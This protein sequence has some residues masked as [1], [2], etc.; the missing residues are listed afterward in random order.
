M[1]NESVALYWDF[2]NLH[3]SLIEKFQGKGAYRNSHYK[4]QHD[5]IDVK[6]VYDF[7]STYGTV[8]VNKAYCNWQFYGKYRSKLLNNSV[9]LIQIFHPGQS[10]KNGA[11]IKLSLDAM[12]DMIRFPQITAVVVV[13]GDSDFIPL[14]QKLK[15]M[16]KDLIGIGEKSSTNKHWAN[17]CTDFKYYEHLEVEPVDGV[18][19]AEIEI[20]AVVEDA[21]NDGEILQIPDPVALISRA[22]RRLSSRSGEEFVRKAGIRPM[23]KRLDPT[24][25]ES[26]YECE[27]F[28]KLLE[29]YADRFEIEKGEFDHMV[30]VL[31]DN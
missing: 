22:I 11:D 23:I 21:H 29:K 2:E 15:A 26:N 27:S 3:A 4:P 28:N 24:F 1:S 14:A 5:V 30:K 8:A 16:G 18:E 7:A 17:S 20:E 13:T 10:S 31:S 25:D 19:E 9:E 12:E 6:A